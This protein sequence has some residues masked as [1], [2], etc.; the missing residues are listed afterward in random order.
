MDPVSKI[1]PPQ[2]SAPT[3]R[4]AVQ[5]VLEHPD[6]TA[7]ELAR[8][9]GREGEH[10]RLELLA[11]LHLAVEQGVLVIGPA[12]TCCVRGTPGATWVASETAVYET[13]DYG[14]RNLEVLIN[15][16]IDSMLGAQKLPV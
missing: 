12:R 11:A 3:W 9:A 5:L 13:P 6:C 2:R 14:L 1:A 10:A 16:A 4:T 15:R 7:G 8:V